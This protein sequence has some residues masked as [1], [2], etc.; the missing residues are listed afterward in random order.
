M[1]LLLR[2]IPL[3]MI[4][5]TIVIMVNILIAV[6]RMTMI[7]ASLIHKKYIKEHHSS[8]KTENQFLN[9]IREPGYA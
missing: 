5:L 7:I 9:H 4:M 3:M 6:I 8:K 1:I 2:T